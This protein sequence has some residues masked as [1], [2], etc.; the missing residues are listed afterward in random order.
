MVALGVAVG[1][2]DVV[3]D[4]P[5]AGLH[6]YVS[7]GLFA[8][9]N[10]TELPE[11]MDIEGPLIAYAAFFVIVNCLLKLVIGNVVKSS[12]PFVPATADVAF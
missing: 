3:D 1:L 12:T 9:P 10:T 4:N 6:A 7:A 8:A 11:H 5:D 2:L